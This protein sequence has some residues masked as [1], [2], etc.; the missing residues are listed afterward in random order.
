MSQQIPAPSVLA[1]K[2]EL[3]LFAKSWVGSSQA[4]AVAEALKSNTSLTFVG[5]RECRTVDNSGA[6]AIADALRVNSTLRKLSFESTK[7]GDRGAAALAAAIPLS[8]LTRLD[9][10]Y[11]SIGNAGALAFA[12]AISSEACQL[13]T[14]HLD[15]CAGITDEGAAAIL[16]AKA[17]NDNCVLTTLGLNGTS[18]SSAMRKRI[19]TAFRVRDTAAR[20]TA[21]ALPKAVKKR[22]RPP[23]SV[24]G[25][26]PAAAATGSTGTNGSTADVKNVATNLASHNSIVT[27]N[28]IAKFSS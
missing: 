5:F 10:G 17:E 12:R 15:Y 14:L 3:N 19:D 20:A 21:A 22:P 27:R 6:L 28:V 11:C 7:V 13:E 24:L 2:K 4:S 9:L 16:T 26:Q 25:D 8:G 23:V 1:Q 18:I